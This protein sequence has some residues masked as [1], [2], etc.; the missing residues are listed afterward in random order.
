MS[1]DTIGSNGSEDVIMFLSLSLIW[2]PFLK[3][4]S[5][6]MKMSSP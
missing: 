2:F 1:L 6:S 4:Y 3:A 5:F